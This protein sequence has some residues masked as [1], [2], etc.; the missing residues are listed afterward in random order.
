MRKIIWIA[1]SAL[2]V[3]CGSKSKDNFTV[4]C[5]ILGLKKGTI[6]LE[7]FEDKKIVV[8]DSVNITDATEEF[9]FTNTI[10]EPELYIISLDKL[11]TKQI[12][13]FGEEGTIHIETSLNKFYINRKISGSSLQE[14]LDKHDEY[15]KKFND[16]NLDLIKDKFEALKYGDTKSVEEI[17]LKR[18]NNLKR[19]YLFSANFAIAYN[20]KAISPFIA[21]HRMEQATPKLKQKIYEA[22]T[23]EIKHSKYG[24][25]LKELIQ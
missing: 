6:Y 11:N 25:Q 5:Q 18:L 14:I 1:L 22:L 3:S 20:D 10:N 15:A 13:F 9:T 17:E 2:V 8:V 23:P 12:T 4:K 7:K 21:C 19:L 16:I 24:K